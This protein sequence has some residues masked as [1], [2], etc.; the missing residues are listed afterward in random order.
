MQGEYVA[1]TCNETGHMPCGLIIYTNMDGMSM[2]CMAL[3]LLDSSWQPARS[4]VL[5]DPRLQVSTSI[6]AN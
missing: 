5:D 4:V 3:E 6:A 2:P 1:L